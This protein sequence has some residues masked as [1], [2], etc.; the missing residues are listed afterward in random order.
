[1]ALKAKFFASQTNWSTP[2]CQVLA[3]PGNATDVLVEFIFA[4]PLVQV[5]STLASDAVQFRRGLIVAHGLY[6]SQSDCREKHSCP[7]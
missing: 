5:V 2:S 1:M 4:S 6:R 3:L 7:A